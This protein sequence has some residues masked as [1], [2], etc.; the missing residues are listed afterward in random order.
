MEFK[1][2]FFLMECIIV[3]SCKQHKFFLVCLK[4]IGFMEY[5]GCNKSIFSSSCENDIHNNVDI[6]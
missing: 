2:K 6:I 4:V 1:I 3:I 5:I